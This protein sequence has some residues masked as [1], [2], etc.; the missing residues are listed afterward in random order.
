MSWLEFDPAKFHLVD[1]MQPPTAEVAVVRAGWG[2]L[3]QFCVADIETVPVSP[4]AFSATA[5]VEY[6]TLQ[7]AEV[8]PLKKG[9]RL[10]FDQVPFINGEPVAEP[11]IFA[12]KVLNPTRDLEIERQIIFRLETHAD[13]PG[14]FYDNLDQDNRVTDE[15]ELEVLRMRIL[16]IEQM[17]WL[18]V[19]E[20]PDSTLIHSMPRDTMFD[21]FEALLA[22]ADEG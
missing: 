22:E 21:G 15:I 10:M 11:G 6:A 19:A 8:D 5:D 17:F 1:D 4:D 13:G 12:L 16:C 7:T 9:R 14:V 2:V 20:L 18:M 3:A